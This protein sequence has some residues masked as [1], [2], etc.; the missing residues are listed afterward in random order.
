M[1]RFVFLASSLAAAL[2]LQIAAATPLHYPLPPNSN[3]RNGVPH[4]SSVTSLPDQDLAPQRAENGL[5]PHAAKGLARRY[6]GT[7][8]DVLRYHNDNYPTGWNQNETDLT[9]AA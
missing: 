5:H 1:R 3:A 8:T 7:V 2:T 4:K 6:A 9:P